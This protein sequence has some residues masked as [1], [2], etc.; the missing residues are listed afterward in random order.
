M[1]QVIF[2]LLGFI[3]FFSMCSGQMIQSNGDTLYGNEWI[4]ENQDYFSFKI[5][6]DGVYR[7]NYSTLIEAGI[8]V[9]AIEHTQLKLYRLGEEQA[10]SV[11]SSSDIM[12]PNDYIEFFGRKMTDD[13]HEYLYVN[14]K[15]DQLNDQYNLITDT[16]CYYLTW[17]SS[18]SKRYTIQKYGANDQKDTL[19]SIH[20]SV[21][22]AGTTRLNKTFDAEAGAHPSHFR[23]YDGFYIATTKNYRERNVELPGL[24]ESANTSSF[25]HCNLLNRNI[26][27]DLAVLWNGDTL[28]N[29]ALFVGEYKEIILEVTS[30][31]VESRNDIFIQN[32]TSDG[33]FNVINY[34]VEFPQ[35]LSGSHAL[36]HIYPSDLRDHNLAFD[37]VQDD[38]RIYF[39]NSDTVV[40][41]EEI[42]DGQCVM[43]LADFEDAELMSAMY[44]SDSHHTITKLT[45]LEIPDLNLG[46]ADYLFLSTRGIFHD[47]SSALN[48]YINYRESEIGGSY[49]VKLLY[50]EDILNQFGYGIPRNFL[51]IKNFFNYLDINNS[52][53]EKVF[54]IGKGRTFNDWRSPEEI[55]NPVFLEAFIPTYG[56]HGSDNMLNSRSST[57]DPIMQIGRLPVT[58]ERQLRTYL[59][60]VMKFDSIRYIENSRVEDVEWQKQVLHLGGG[61][62]EQVIIRDFLDSL[63]S[64]VIDSRWN[65]EVTSFY[66]TSADPI[67]TAQSEELKKRINDGV[68]IITFFG[69]SSTGSFDF[70]LEDPSEYKSFGKYPVM[71]SMGCISGDVNSVIFGLAEQFVLEPDGGAIAYMASTGNAYLSSLYRMGLK[72]YEQLTREFDQTLGKVHRVA[73]DSLESVNFT[74][75]QDL[76]E[77]FVLVGDPALKIGPVEG[78][79]YAV[80]Y[81]SFEAL[82]NEIVFEDESFAVSFDLHSLHAFEREELIL[83]YELEQEGTWTLLSYDTVDVLSSR[84]TLQREFEIPDSITEGI[85]YFHITID[86]FN[87][88]EETPQPKAENNNRLGFSNSREGFKLIFLEA[89]ARFLYPTNYSI[90][91]QANPVFYAQSD[92]LFSTEKNYLFQ[93]DTTA[94]FDSPFLQENMIISKGGAVTWQPSVSW[95][96]DRVYYIRTKLETA[97]AESDLWDE[98]SFIYRPESEKGWN[99]SHKGQFADLELEDVQLDSTCRFNFD[100]LIIEYNIRNLF[101]ID[102]NSSPPE[103]TQNNER[104]VANFNPRGLM[105]VL[106]KDGTFE[107]ISNDSTFVDYGPSGR[108]YFL[109]NNPDTSDRNLVMRFMNEKIEDGDY[110]IFMPVRKAEDTTNFRIDEWA[111]DSIYYGRN[112]FQE[113]EKEGAQ[114]IRSLVDNPRPYIFVYR[115]GS[116]PVLEV[117]G[118]DFYDDIRRTIGFS[119]PQNDGRII[120]ENI[121]LS[122][123]FKRLELGILEKDSA[124]IVGLTMVDESV[125]LRADNISPEYTFDLESSDLRFSDQMSVELDFMDT[126]SNTMPQ[127]DYLRVYHQGYPE[128][129]YHHEDSIHW[130]SS[131]VSGTDQIVDFLV[132]NYS[133]FDSDSMRIRYIIRDDN[134]NEVAWDEIYPEMD[135]LEQ[136][137]IKVQFETNDLEGNLE[138]VIELNPE[139]Q[140]REHLSINNFATLPFEVISDKTS[141]FLEVRFDGNLL[142]YGALVNGHP[143]IDIRFW[144]Y[145][146]EFS[147]LDTNNIEV[148]LRYPDSIDYTMLNYASGELIFD[149]P[150]DLNGA[151]VSFDPIL[152]QE[153]IYSLLVNAEGPNGRELSYEVEF[154]YQQNTLFETPFFTPNPIGSVAYLNLD[155]AG[156]EIPELINLRVWNSQGIQLADL[157]LLERNRINIG[158]NDVLLDFNDRNTFPHHMP[159]GIYPYE[160]M[161]QFPNGG[162]TI[163]FSGKLVLTR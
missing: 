33:K 131:L 103:I 10:L 114:D 149:K 35:L 15:D 21:G 24:D 77:Q 90:L 14:G 101:L 130:S 155:F 94:S 151:E 162:R 25:L 98:R 113:L 144:D 97:S 82:Q 48:D 32:V 40:I 70:K 147:D 141:P 53:P 49:E 116:G 29:E 57:F 83:K 96:L 111:E 127:L 163:E 62:S 31:K 138:F 39:S 95:E 148:M 5:G 3:G 2:F 135:S 153:G 50:Y 28:Y 68:S 107:P 105:F 26:E 23:K 11:W 34:S 91:T 63:E 78:K 9:D 143:E 84:M 12:S 52:L 87:E 59:D 108:S 80:S 72:H 136:R 160:I 81:S 13:L 159:A 126:I 37:N 154:E 47:N 58:S 142:P 133:N 89:K 109:W 30:E 100:G 43:D 79:D 73:L 45:A 139:S 7:I 56:F 6:E 93:I 120:S 112:L 104:V 51:S 42:M 145:D 161:Y 22:L 74:G 1:K 134:N 41:A 75:M 38:F 88:I 66:K 118:D 4:E 115:K 146:S 69:H 76:R 99:Q 71:Y 132:G 18:A 27:G 117:V 119:I 92:R 150:N 61:S 64:M 128:F 19:S 17:S 85:A 54:I 122:K 102:N 44:N 86:P 152:Q 65:G 158:E 55:S 121:G 156:N 124:D 123:D 137:R 125:L 106:V 46:G 140:Q 67:Q 8:P 60:K 129:Y 110:V 16:S 157:D 36:I 20:N